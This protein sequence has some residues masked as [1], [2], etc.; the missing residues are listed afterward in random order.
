M[1]SRSMRPSVLHRDDARSRREE[2]LG[3]LSGEGEGEVHVPPKVS[4][5][6]SSRC[7]IAGRLSGPTSQGCERGMISQAP[8]GPGRALLTS[9][10]CAGAGPRCRVTGI[11]EVS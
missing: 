11:Q 8:A 1:R 6:A 9:S 10:L 5:V 4:S 3:E 7:F 2:G